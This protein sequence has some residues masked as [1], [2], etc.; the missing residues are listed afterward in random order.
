MG[1][2]SHRL[3][4]KVDNKATGSV[5]FAAHVNCAHNC[6]TVYTCQL[7]R[8]KKWNPQPSSFLNSDWVWRSRGWVMNTKLLPSWQSDRHNRNLMEFHSIFA[9]IVQLI[10]APSINISHHKF[11]RIWR[12]WQLCNWSKEIGNWF[13]FKISELTCF[14][15]SGRHLMLR[16]Y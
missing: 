13:Q 8:G 6:C 10:R 2:P 5:R 15:A 7:A 14:W 9:I 4:C 1:S 16:N 3:G 11:V 12:I